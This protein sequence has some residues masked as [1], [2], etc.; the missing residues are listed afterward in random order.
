MQTSF[1]LIRKYFPNIAFLHKLYKSL[2]F[3]IIFYIPFSMVQNQVYF[4]FIS[5][6]VSE[7]ENG[8]QKAAGSLVYLFF[9]EGRFLLAHKEFQAHLS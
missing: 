7:N 5:Q 4:L 2:I 9:L 8:K 6:N 1:L 3:A